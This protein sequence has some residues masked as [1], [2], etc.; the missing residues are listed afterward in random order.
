MLPIEKMFVIKNVLVETL[1]SIS[2][3]LTILNANIF[4][5]K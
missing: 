3:P 1:F 4:N 2:A 5:V